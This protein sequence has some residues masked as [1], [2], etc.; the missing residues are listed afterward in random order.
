MTHMT[1]SAF[2]IPKEIS[3]DVLRHIAQVRVW[4]SEM[5]LLHLD[6]NR[7]RD[8]ANQGRYFGGLCGAESPP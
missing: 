3:K 5:P 7:A 2:K 4:V 1:Q 8:A 6:H